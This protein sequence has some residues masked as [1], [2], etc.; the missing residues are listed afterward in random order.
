MI[1]WWLV[2]K[3]STWSMQK[4]GFDPWVGKIPWRRKWQ[5]IPAFLPGKSH[6][7]RIL[8]GYMVSQIAGHDLV[9]ELSNWTTTTILLLEKD[10]L[11]QTDKTGEDK[12]WWDQQRYSPM[13]QKRKLQP[14]S[15][16]TIHL[17]LTNPF[18]RQVFASTSLCFTS[19][20]SNIL[21][22]EE[23]KEN[24]K[25]LVTTTQLGC[26]S[27][28]A[29]RDDASMKMCHCILTLDLQN[30]WGTGFGPWL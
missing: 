4:Q 2:S 8:E 14:I 26:W 1:P 16:A 27:R 22:T 21:R 18:I 19:Y 28:K 9:T 15:H 30:R 7:Q 3:E 23:E 24:F 11:K 20:S 25:T 13:E 12:I 17:P 5:P 10:L 29:A 6:G